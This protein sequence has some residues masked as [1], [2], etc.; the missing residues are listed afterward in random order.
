MSSKQPG[1]HISATFVLQPS[2][3]YWGQHEPVLSSSGLTRVG[4]IDGLSLYSNIA[5]L[6]FERGCKSYHR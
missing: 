1:R 6:S 4:N 5:V 2:L 3:R